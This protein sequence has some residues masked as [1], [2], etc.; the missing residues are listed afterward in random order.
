MKKIAFL[1]NDL[2]MGG[3]EKCVIT[4]VRELAASGHEITLVLM[5][6]AD[7]FWGEIGLGVRVFDVSADFKNKRWWQWWK[8][9]KDIVKEQD[10]LIAG[11][12]LF[13]TYMMVL[14]GWRN[15]CQQIAW[16]HGPLA[17]IHR[18][19]PLHPFHQ[20]IGR[21]MYRHLKTVVFVSHQAKKSMAKWVNTAI[22]RGWKVIH[23]FVPAPVISPKPKQVHSPLNLLF[24]GRLTQEK[25]PFVLI[26]TIA[27]LLQKRVPVKLTIVGNGE[28]LTSLQTRV[29][30]CKLT[31][32]IEFAGSQHILQ[33]YID[34]ADFLLLPS[35]F[36]G[37]PLVILEA[38]QRGLPVIASRV[39]GIPELVGPLSAQLLIDEPDAVLMSDL[40]M[41]NLDNYHDLSSACL[42]R[43]ELFTAEVLMPQWH[44]VIGK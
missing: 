3:A 38:M 44:E 36:E 5:R 40:I 23:N 33:S 35:Q 22:K 10:I 29:Q 17:E 11:N 21:L 24:I 32:Y 37:C 8:K 28:M 6:R 34:E 14:L 20:L 19:T 13:P 27:L 42:L 43:S 26:E 18:L 25:N 31:P 12:I 4:L 2:S 39:G 41:A 7:N 30:E 1:L 9:L 15:S 16:V